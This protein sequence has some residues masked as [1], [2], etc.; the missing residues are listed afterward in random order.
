MEFETV[1]AIIAEQ[2]GVDAEDI[3]EDTDILEDLNA[4]SMDAVEL[5]VAIESA[6]DIAIPDEAVD[7]IHTVGDVVAYLR[8]HASEEE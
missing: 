3:T 1:A 7:N 4:T 5:I 6:T 8:E 2:F